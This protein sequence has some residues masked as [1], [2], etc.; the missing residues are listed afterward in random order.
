MRPTPRP[1]ARVHRAA[2]C[3][4]AFALGAG[5]AAAQAGEPQA[6]ETPASLAHLTQTAPEKP[7]TEPAA[8]PEP[9]GLDAVL[10]DLPFK[11]SLD[12]TASYQ[13]TSG[14]PRDTDYLVGYV[15]LVFEGRIAEGT[16]ALVELE[17]MGGTGPDADVP[18]LSG[19][20]YGWNGLVGSADVDTWF[21][22]V[23]FGEVLLSTDAL[24]GGF[25][26]D[27]GQIGSTSYLD[28]NRFANDSTTQFLSGDFSNSAALQVPYR[29][30]GATLAYQGSE[31]FAAALV[32]MHDGASSDVIDDLLLAGQ[33]SGF[34]T[35]PG[36]RA[37]ALHAYAYQNGAADDQ[38]GLGLSVDQ[39]VTDSIGAFGR[40][41]WQQKHGS[42][43]EEV[44]RAWSVGLQIVG[45][46]P[47]CDDDVLGLAFGD[48]TSADGALD[49]EL[50]WEAYYQRCLGEHVALSLH[51]QGMQH[52][53]GDPT[54]GTVLAFGLRLHLGF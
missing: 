3:I 5:R 11:V 2:A 46:I 52:P 30:A 29:A 37:G 22:E 45:P 39:G 44:I 33:V 28:P 36:E 23:E 18:S 24:G 4:V 51:F 31:R 54:V 42:L 16:V 7:A 43:A 48:N 6:A 38:L 50:V 32:A 21:D 26:L 35:A 12:L 40:I 10:A 9:K 49:D 25:V 8:A 15:D 17:G 34:W 47:G 19:T 14:A 27:V 13:A 53:G 1:N 20:L 41:G